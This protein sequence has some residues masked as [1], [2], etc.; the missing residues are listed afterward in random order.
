MLLPA[1]PRTPAA[2]LLDG[3]GSQYISRRIRDAVHR[4]AASGRRIKRRP[5]STAAAAAAIPALQHS[6]RRRRDAGD[7]AGHGGAALRRASGGRPS[8][9]APRRLY[10]VPAGG[11]AADGDAERVERDRARRALRALGGPAMNEINEL[12]ERLRNSVGEV[13]GVS[14]VEISEAAADHVRRGVR[15]VARAVRRARA[16]VARLGRC[17]RRRRAAR[18]LRGRKFGV[19]FTLEV[20]VS[21]AARRPG[22]VL[23]V[24]EE[25]SSASRRSEACASAQAP[26]ADLVRDTIAGKVRAPAADRPPPPLRRRRRRRAYRPARLVCPIA[27]ALAR[28]ADAA[29]VAAAAARE[30]AQ[31]ARRAAADDG[32]AAAAAHRRD[33]TAALSGAAPDGGDGADDGDLHALLALRQATQAGLARALDGELAALLH[34]SLFELKGG[35]RRV[36]RPTPSGAPPSSSRCSSCG[37]TTARACGRRSCSPA[38]STPRCCGAR[39]SAC[40]SCACRRR[41][42]SRP[43]YKILQ[44]LHGRATPRVSSNSVFWTQRTHAAANREW[45]SEKPPTGEPAAHFVEQKWASSRRATSRR[46]RDRRPALPRQLCRRGR[47][48]QAEGQQD[49]QGGRDQDHRQG[50][51]GGHGGYHARDRDHAG[52]QLPERDQPL[53]D[54]R[55]AQEDEPGDGG[56][57]AASSSTASSP[58]AA[59]PR[60]TPRCLKELSS[61]LKYLHEKKIVHRDLKP[62]NLLYDSPAEDANRVADLGSRAS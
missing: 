2:P 4:H 16:R 61:A 14:E 51:G 31:G 49:P 37:T 54:L 28:R 36:N 52:H 45:R 38:P 27:G 60:K 5:C 40:A 57:W 15:G 47:R 17:R 26:P 41:P 13:E 34:A 46:T 22:A 24:S 42:T 9:G 55:R 44:V 6:W 1:S 12:A 21:S 32:E 20:Q 39:W 18:P 33:P 29:R 7:A 11:A 56:R 62:E 58:R 3:D 25:G 23:L 35:G 53:R 43:A 30:V 19:T 10:D 48:H 50:E 59:T 8:A